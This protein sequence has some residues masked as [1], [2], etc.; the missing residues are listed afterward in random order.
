M[1]G[2]AKLLKQNVPVA[3]C[4]LDPVEEIPSGLSQSCVSVSVLVTVALKYK[5]TVSVVEKELMAVGTVQ[6]VPT[7]GVFVSR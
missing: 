5:Y 4:Q 3:V 1:L 6:A 2:R 7:G